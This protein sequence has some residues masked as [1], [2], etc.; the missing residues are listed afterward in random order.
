MKVIEGRGAAPGC[1]R[2][3]VRRCADGA[4]CAVPRT[5]DD[6]Q[7]EA[8]KLRRAR[9]D[10]AAALSRLRV[11]EADGSPAADIL[12]AYREI[13]DDDVF[14]EP[15]V[16]RTLSDGLN[17][18]FSLLREARETAGLFAQMDDPYLAARAGDITN[19]CD[20]LILRIQGAVPADLSAPAG[21]GEKWV[22]FARDLTPDAALR[23]D[24]S[25]LAGF[26]TEQG[27]LTS[28]TVILARSLGIPAVVGA[29]G[30][31]EAAV[32]GETVLL[33]GD[34]GRV[35]LDPDEAALAAFRRDRDGAEQL[36]AACDAAMIREAATLDGQRIHVCVNLGDSGADLPE[37]CDGVGLLRTEF[38]YLGTDHSPTEE[39][40]YRHYAAVAAQAGGRE[41]IIRTLDIGGDKQAEYLALPREAN[42]FLGCRA[43]RLCLDRRELFLTQLRAVLRAGLSGNV[44]VMF[45]MIASLK[46]LREAKALL[47]QAGA[48]LRAAGTPFRGDL[49]VGVM[50]ETP[51]AVQISDALAR[52]AD[53]F[54]IGTNDLI[55]YT[56]AADR[57]N[58]R[59]QYL[60]DVCS[61]AVLRSIRTVTRNAA[62]AGIPVGM[63]GEAAA[64]PLLA[65]LW[66]AMGLNE[67]SVVPAQVARTKYAVGRVDAGALRARLPGLLDLDGAEEIRTALAEIQREYQTMPGSE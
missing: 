4:V 20:A 59:V 6:R 64:D 16:R 54:S 14:F 55:Q 13:L 7:A 31:L 19:V 57:M 61:P 9:A 18:D 32:D 52:E 37:H 12:D 63:C 30:A 58:E 11:K 29:P 8:E 26:V 42:P 46:E 3:V 28:H 39:E 17:V 56:M 53:F 24:R 2:A 34:T 36:Q 60:Y 5:V 10:Y 62:I 47:A 35:I 48:Q 41:V 21:P 49:P 33:Y 45:P 67:L 23:M 15:V 22:V 38:I 25:A 44:K 1:V 43:I 50:I 65:P 66:C 27:G 51:A 40:Q